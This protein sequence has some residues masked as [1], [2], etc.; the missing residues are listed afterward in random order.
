ML[1][2]AILL[3]RSDLQYSWHRNNKKNERKDTKQTIND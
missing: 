2:F 3:H 1:N